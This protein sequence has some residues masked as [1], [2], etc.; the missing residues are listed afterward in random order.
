MLPAPD[1]L[2]LQVTAV[3]LVLTTVAVNFCCWPPLF[4]KTAVDGVTLTATGGISV[5]VA[6]TEVD[7]LVAV[8]VMVC[9]VVMLAGAV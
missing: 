5:T 8:T 4:V 9:W 1:G 7:P 6:E 3:L 2:T